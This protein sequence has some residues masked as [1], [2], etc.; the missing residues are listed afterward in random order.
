MVDSGEL[1]ALR[2]SARSRLFSI[3]EDGVWDEK[4]VLFSMVMVHH[5][6]RE[7]WWDTFSFLALQAHES[8]CPQ[9]AWVNIAFLERHI[10]IREL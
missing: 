4:T 3:D 7:S 9:E 2:R 1:L 5:V 6:P 10:R 8:T